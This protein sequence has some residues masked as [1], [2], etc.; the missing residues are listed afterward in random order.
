MLAPIVKDNLEEI[1]KLLRKHK[2]KRAFAFGSV[3]DNRFTE[4][5]DVDI[6]LSFYDEKISLEE[7][8]D[9]YFDLAYQLEDLLG[10]DVDLVT[11]RSIKDPLLIK[12]INKTKTPIFGE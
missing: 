5:S 3:C 7:Y 9:N 8:A 10:R 12:S 4:T 11:E 6:L 2:V 1:N